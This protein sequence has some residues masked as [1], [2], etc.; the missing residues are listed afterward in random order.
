MKTVKTFAFAALAL[1]AAQSFA[2][3]THT[4]TFRR[5]NGTILS[6][7]EVAHG[8]SVTAP[9]LPAEN[10]M[11]AKKWDFVEKLANVTN[12]V[13][14]WALYEASTAKSPSTSIASQSVANRETPYS[15]EEYFKMYDNLAWSDEFSGSS[16]SVGYGSG[17]NWNYDTE[18]GSAD[19]AVYTRGGNHEVSD[20]T[21]KLVCKRESANRITSARVNTKGRV[22][23]KLGRCEMRAKI[24]KQKGGTPAFWTMGSN[25]GWPQGGEIDIMEQVNGSDWIAGTLHMPRY[26]SGS[27]IE[28]SQGLVTYEDGVHWGDGFH[29]IGVIVNE[30]EMVWYVDDHIFQRMDIRDAKYDILRN[31][32]Q[33]LLLNFNFGGNWAGQTNHTDSSIVNFQREEFEVDYCRIYTNTN[34][35]NTISREPAAPQGAPLSGPVKAAT[36]RG[37]QMNWGKSGAGYYQSHFIGG[38]AAVHIQ[39]AM[40]EYFTR[41]DV[42]VTTF[43]TRVQADTGKGNVMAPYDVP[44]YTTVNLSPNAGRGW[45]DWDRDSR[46]KLLSTVMFKSGRFSQSDSAVSTLQ[47]SNDYSFTNGC[48][49]V[50]E[51]VEKDT[52]AKVKVV[53]AFVSTTNGVGTSGSAAA[54]GFDTLI[55][56][57]NAMK[58]EKVILLLQ[59][60]TYSGWNY[61][62]NR[63]N[64]ELKPAFAKLGQYTSTWP[65][66]HSAWA[67]SNYM[68][69]AENPAPLSV[70]RAN[71]Q[72]SGVHTNQSFC[73]T[74]QFE[75]PH[76]IEYGQL[77]MSGFAKKMTV[78]F[79]GAQ[80][81]TTLTDFPVLVKL[82]TAINGFSYSDFQLANG[83]DLRFA[84]STGKLLPHEVDTWNP[85]GV[86]TVWVAGAMPAICLKSPRRTSGTT[87]TWACGIWAK[88]RCPS[89]SRAKRRATSRRRR[90]PASAMQL[91]AS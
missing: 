75:A 61:L 17:K 10:G 68:A 7:V 15:L 90:G 8:G 22:A 40:R 21:F 26:S 45:T 47:L 54:Q 4:V 13:T 69:S 37:W 88:A 84:D 59:G 16:L 9:A 79:V 56:K 6:K 19:L 44:G 30:R 12:D 89:R 55:S 1:C 76:V 25:A 81:G 49:V 33:Y 74:V 24:A 65:S 51:L 46:E 78:T 72:A 32:S 35:N 86:S 23:F 53:S 39:S 57:I 66:Y 64:S 11:T 67:T 14:C 85:S 2:E 80:S 91:R 3:N 63:V 20:G 77:D 36:W 38:L 73:A 50:A 48:A 83:G 71:G 62:N 28:S 5:M 34:A 41:D 27:A 58:D 70:R 31:Y 87:T 42:D 82:S 43:F 52:G 29:R 60:E 18:Q